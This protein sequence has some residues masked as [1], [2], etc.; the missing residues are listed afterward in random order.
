M[1]DSGYVLETNSTHRDLLAPEDLLDELS[2]TLP[3]SSDV[4][5]WIWQGSVI[6]LFLIDLIGI[7]VLL[8]CT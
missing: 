1:Y 5:P 6:Y 8:I 4:T 3:S 7:Q 2:P